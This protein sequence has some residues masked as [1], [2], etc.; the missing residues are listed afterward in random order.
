MARSSHGLG[1]IPNPEDILGFVGRELSLPPASR[2]IRMCLGMQHVLG[3]SLHPVLP[4]ETCQCR[5]A[6]LDVP[7]SPTPCATLK[8]TQRCPCVQIMWLEGQ[9]LQVTDRSRSGMHPGLFPPSMDFGELCSCC[10]VPGSWTVGPRVAHLWHCHHCQ[11]CLLL[12]VP[13]HPGPCPLQCS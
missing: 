13:S 3:A 11:P 7:L 2:G 4:H 8:A 1:V 12:L 6:P 9:W 10:R 5:V